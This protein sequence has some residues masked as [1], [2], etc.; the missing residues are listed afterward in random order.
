MFSNS[1]DCEIFVQEEIRFERASNIIKRINDYGIKNK[2]DFN[3]E[4]NSCYNIQIRTF[5]IKR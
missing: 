4:N 2:H 1:I 5:V 3:K